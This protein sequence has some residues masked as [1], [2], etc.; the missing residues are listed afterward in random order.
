MRPDRRNRVAPAPDRPNRARTH[1]ALR[2]RLAACAVVLLGATSPAACGREAPRPRTPLEPVLPEGEAHPSKAAP[3]ASPVAP[4]G[5][6][7]SAPV[8]TPPG[9]PWDHAAALAT[10]RRAAGP[11][12]SQHLGGDLVAEVLVNDAAKPYPAI[13]PATRPSADAMLVEALRRAPEGEPVIYFVMMRR[14]AGF[15][16]RGGDWEYLVVDRD[17]R[18][19]QRGVL[20]L[21]ARC[22]AEAPAHRLFGPPRP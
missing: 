8:A 14:E 11:F 19:V 18:A 5:A 10:L 4:A 20:P 17:G 7:A 6:A 13:G 12:P 15:D 16:P 21:C 1:R 9:P 2:A 3:S 22:H